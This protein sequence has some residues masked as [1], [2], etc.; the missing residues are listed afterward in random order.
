MKKIQ[1]MRRILLPTMA[2]VGVAAVTVPVITSCSK[3][4]LK[5]AQSSFALAQ[6]DDDAQTTVSKG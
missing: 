6:L 3:K 1:L 5:L 2:V 4:T